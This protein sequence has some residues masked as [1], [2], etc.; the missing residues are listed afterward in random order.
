MTALGLEL[1]TN[2]KQSGMIIK[3]TKDG[4][5]EF[6]IDITGNDDISINKIINTQDGG[7]AV[8]G[9]FEST[10]IYVNGA[11]TGITGDGTRNGMLLKFNSTGEYQWGGKLEGTGSEEL[12]S[13]IQLNDGSY[14]VGGS[15]TSESLSVNG[16]ILTNMSGKDGVIAG[17]TSTGT[18]DWAVRMAGTGKDEV[19][20]LTKAAN[21][22]IAVIGNYEGELDLDGDDSYELTSIGQQDGFFAK[23]DTNGNL[24]WYKTI[25]SSNTDRLNSI[26]TLEDGNYVIVGSYGGDVDLDEDSTNDLTTKGSFDGMIL[27]YNSTGTFISSQT[28]GGNADDV[29]SSVVETQDGG[30]LIG[31]YT[32]STGIDFNGDSVNDKYPLYGY[33]DGFIVKYDS[34]YNYS[35]NKNI[36]GNGMDEVITVSEL[37][38]GEYIAGGW[39]SSTSL[40]VGQDSTEEN[41]TLDQY[42]DAFLVKY[43]DIVVSPE[44]PDTQEIIVENELK[45]YN[46][47][48][49]VIPING[50]KGGTISGD[51]DEVYETVQHGKNSV[52]EI[53][54]TPNT[55]YKILE[56]KV[57]D[58]VVSFTP[59]VDGSYTLD[60]FTNV[61]TDKHVTVTFSNTSSSVVVHHYLK[62]STTKVAEDDM[63]TGIIGETYTTV[64]HIDLEDYELEKDS[65]GNFILPANASGTFVADQTEVIY[66]YVE[67]EIPLVVHHY[68]EGTEESVPLATG[69]V[70]E[71]EMYSGKKGEGD[72]TEALSIDE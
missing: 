16:E 57:N 46:I 44:I 35:W 70:A 63:I 6:V 24:D 40:N 52:K 61:T 60:L 55:G 18:L 31:G 38:T 30:L 65:S 62:D 21:G 43:G 28:L 56:I 51:G 49:E 5:D 53:V 64:P 39:F 37:S 22:E 2:N 48:T 17:Y 66:Y 1:T 32:Y 29:I 23:Y 20:A 19:V 42:T 26:I 47:S 34:D 15:F 7:F 14:A 11:N 33:T 45:K 4:F 3:Y 50:I 41:L 59:E 71:D 72:T 58:E 36:T 8:V 27:K 10:N 68:I 69:G 67:K 25:G 54:I 12:T 13:L 9:Y